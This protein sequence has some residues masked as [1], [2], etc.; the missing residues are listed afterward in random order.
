MEETKEMNDI[1]TT[2]LLSL[3]A[4]LTEMAV[5]GT[6]TKVSNKIRAIKK[7]KMLRKCEIHMTKL[8]MN[9]LM[10]EKKRFVLY[11]RIKLN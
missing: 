1:C 10:N 11:K 9:C 2:E 6:A 7:E 4:T 5:K 3:G 8:L